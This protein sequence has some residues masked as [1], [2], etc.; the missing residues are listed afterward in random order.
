[1]VSDGA[2]ASAIARVTGLSRQA[3][4]RIRAGPVKGE[5][6]VQPDTLDD[7][8]RGEVRENCRRSPVLS[9]FFVHGEV[10]V[11][12]VVAVGSVPRFKTDNAAPDPRR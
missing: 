5:R 1:M 2:G 6:P 7:A 4:L 3:V 12:Y 11:N 8:A 9:V 10:F